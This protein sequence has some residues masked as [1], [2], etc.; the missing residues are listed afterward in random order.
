M[1][2]LSAVPQPDVNITINQN[3][4]LYAGSI[5]T[6]TCTATLDPYVAKS[7][8]IIVAIE[9]S[10][11][12][13]ISGNSIITPAVNSSSI[14]ASNLTISHL[15]TQDSGIYTCTVMV[16]GGD[17]VQQANANDSISITVDQKKTT[18]VCIH[19]T[20]IYYR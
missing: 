6:L 14:Y 20:H 10:G 9:W 3:P 13:N 4:P 17:Y 8:S 16:T 7:G 2:F 1:L 12:R 15:E 19:L 18:G 11:L 5:L